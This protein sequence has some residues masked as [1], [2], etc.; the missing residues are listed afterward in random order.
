MISSFCYENQC[1]GLFG[2]FQN[3]GVLPFQPSE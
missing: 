1:E 2:S 3:A